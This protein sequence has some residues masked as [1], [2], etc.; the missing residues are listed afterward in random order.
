MTDTKPA[1]APPAT[2]A[3]VPVAAGVEFNLDAFPTAQFNRLIP[4]QTIRMPGDLFVPMV[5]IVQLD[6][7]DPAGKSA[8][9]YKSNDVPGGHRALTARGLNKV[10]SASSVSF[11]DERRTDDGSD[12]NVMAV[13][14]L[15]SMTLPTGLRIT[16]PGSQLID[17]RSWFGPTTSAAEIAKFRKQ[18]YANVS[19][20]A[21]NRAIRGLLS[22]K[23]SYTDAEIA[24]PFAA[25]SFAPNMANPEVRARFLDA[26]APSVAQLY[27]P[28]AA[29]Q[30]AAGQVIEV[31]EAPED[32]E[33]EGVID[34]QAQDA[35]PEPSWFGTTAAAPEAAATQTP[36]MRLAAVLREKAAS[37]GM[38]GPA[39]APQKE[40]LQLVFKPLGLPATAKGLQVVF[41]LASL[42]EITGAQA[43][44]VIEASVDAEFPD[45]WRELV[46]GDGAQAG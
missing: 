28:E 22:M 16:A 17:I 13:S 24:K 21:K 25:V 19:T 30:L 39:T 23:S 27:G 42:G 38:V 34:G 2:S 18:F 11:F 4:I 1:T 10:A 9:H 43:Q 36:A 7:A 45:L 44:A 5:Q 37:S 35:G 40:R 29:P 6:P 12:P 33:D 8:D 32:D 41:G 3:L 26:M 20:R 31:R 46:A 15:A 14:V